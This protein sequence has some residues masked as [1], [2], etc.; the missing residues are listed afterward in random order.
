MCTDPPLQSKLGATIVS[1]WIYKGLGERMRILLVATQ[2]VWCVTE[3]N[4]RS[5]AFMVQV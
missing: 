5:P 4:N 1:A 2:S 3:F